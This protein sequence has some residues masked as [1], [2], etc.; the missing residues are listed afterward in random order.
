MIA[1]V[2]VHALVEQTNALSYSCQSSAIDPEVCPQTSFAWLLVQLAEM[3]NH[4]IC[5]ERLCDGFHHP[6]FHGCVCL[7]EY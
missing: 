2:F 6:W 3:E 1:K 5:Y 7:Y 4:G